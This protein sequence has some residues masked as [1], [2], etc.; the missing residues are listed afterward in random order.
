MYNM[1]F[2]VVHQKKENLK[3]EREENKNEL[4]RR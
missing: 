4:D 1:V 2:V 3:K